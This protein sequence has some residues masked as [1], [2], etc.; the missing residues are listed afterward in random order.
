MTDFRKHLKHLTKY[1][2]GE[3]LDDVLLWLPIGNA[4][5][6]HLESKSDRLR[7]RRPFLNQEIKNWPDNFRE[8]IMS[9]SPEMDPAKYREMPHEIQNILSQYSK[10]ATAFSERLSNA[11]LCFTMKGYVG[12]FPG[13]T[14]VDDEICLLHGGRVPFVIRKR[15]GE[16]Y[17]LVGEC[18]IHGVMHGEAWNSNLLERRF[19]LV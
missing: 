1:P 13:N 19:Q 17:T 3:S 18:Y 12:L 2:T 15:D 8:A 16:F 10:T 5:R 6:P 9:I 14:L 11:K 4:K 7:S